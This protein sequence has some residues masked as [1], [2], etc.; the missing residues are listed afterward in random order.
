MTAADAHDNQQPDYAGLIETLGLDQEQKNYLTSRWLDQV[1]WMEG[2]AAS[3]QKSHYRWR[4]VAIA[5]GILVP[6]LG[7]FAKASDVA[8]GA[9]VIIGLLVALATALEEF[10]KFG[11]RWRHYRR[12]IEALRK[13]WWSYYGQ[14]GSYTGQDHAAGFC[15]FAE[16]VEKLIAADVDAFLSKVTAEGKPKGGVG[17]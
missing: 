12:V 16:Q 13:E 1:N 15:G 10:F 9:V 17:G 7:A 5:G 6:A 14:S 2:R 4:V 3:F 8:Q 11:E